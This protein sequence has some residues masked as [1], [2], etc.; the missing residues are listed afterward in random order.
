MKRSKGIS[1]AAFGATLSTAGR[2]ETKPAEKP[3]ALKV[4]DRQ[5][6]EF[7]E[8]NKWVVVVGSWNGTK[9][10]EVVSE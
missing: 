2:P 8:N 6:F 9:F 4:G 7:W 10:E 1:A 3:K 5:S